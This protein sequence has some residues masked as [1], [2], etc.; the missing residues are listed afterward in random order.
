MQSYS[1]EPLRI[2]LHCR[3]TKP[4]YSPSLNQRPKACSLA[5]KYASP[6]NSVIAAVFILC[7][8]YSMVPRH[9]LVQSRCTKE[10]PYAR[11]N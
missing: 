9:P 5:L 2:S 1:Q 6:C 7:I 8:W 11:A 10:Q 3:Q 4:P